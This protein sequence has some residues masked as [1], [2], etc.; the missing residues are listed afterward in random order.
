MIA[1]AFCLPATLRS[2]LV[3]APRSPAL[4]N[5]RS[6]VGGGGEFLKSESESV[7]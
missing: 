7:D 6:N 4:G 1:F 5:I 2:P 3:P